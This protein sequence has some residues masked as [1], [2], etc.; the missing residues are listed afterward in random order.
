MRLDQFQRIMPKADPATWFQ[1]IAHAMTEFQINTPRRMAAFLANLAVESD[2][3][4][5]VVENLNYSAE[6]LARTWPGRFA[7]EDKTP[8]G[9]ALDLARL[10]ERIANYAYADRMG[11]GP[12][13]SGD[14]WLYRGAGPLQ[15]TGKNNQQTA[16]MALGCSVLDVGAWLRTPEGGARSAARYWAVAGCNAKAD[17]GDFDG[18]CDLVNIGRKTDKVGDAIGFADRAEFYKTACAVMGVA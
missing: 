6:G 17:A 12:A 9:I 11:N 1:H 4:R 16:A 7:N 13:S 18:C 2:Q 15:I 8:N 5:T 14:G 3:L 10:P